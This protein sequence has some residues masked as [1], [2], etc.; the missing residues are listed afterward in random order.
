[1]ATRE[2]ISA[3]YGNLLSLKLWPCWKLIKVC[4]G[5]HGSSPALFLT[6]NIS[7]KWQDKILFFLR[8]NWKKTDF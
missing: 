4:C 6:G 1:M 7:R 2:V 8:K 3:K 5:F